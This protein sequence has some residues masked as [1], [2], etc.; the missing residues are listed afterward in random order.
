MGAS[1]GRP[2]RPSVVRNAVKDARLSFDCMAVHDD[3]VPY[4]EQS[5]VL[6]ALGL[7]HYPAIL[8]M[9]NG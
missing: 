3:S 1:R 7:K 2:E 8:M 4:F 6:L 9:R 5:M